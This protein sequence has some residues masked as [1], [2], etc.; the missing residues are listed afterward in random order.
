MSVSIYGIDTLPQNIKFQVIGYYDKD[1]EGYESKIENITF[2]PKIKFASKASLDLFEL[3]YKGATIPDNFKKLIK[4]SLE[5]QNNFGELKPNIQETKE[6]S[7]GLPFLPNMKNVQE[8]NNIRI[9]FKNGKFMIGN[10]EIELFDESIN[11]K[12]NSIDEFNKI[13]FLY[14][15]YKDNKYHVASEINTILKQVNDN[16]YIIWDVINNKQVQIKLDIRKNDIRQ[17]D[18][19]YVYLP[20]YS[21]I[22]VYYVYGYYDDKLIYFK[23]V[24]YKIT[25]IDDTF[26]DIIKK[27]KNHIVESDI[28]NIDIHN[29]E[30]YIT[31]YI[32]NI[33]K[34]NLLITN[35]FSINDIINAFYKVDEFINIIKKIYKSDTYIIDSAYQSIINLY[36]TFSS[37]L[38]DNANKI[39]VR[40]YDKNIIE[41]NIH[42]YVNSLN[43]GN[44]I[45]N[46]NM[47]MNKLNSTIHFLN[48]L[49]KDEGDSIIK[50][51]DNI[52]SKI[53]DI[54]NNIKFS[55]MKIRYTETV[56]KLKHDLTGYITNP[57]VQ[58][59][60]DD[61]NE[62]TFDM[63]NN[64]ILNSIKTKLNNTY[65][66]DSNISEILEK[67]YIQSYDH[68]ILNIL[69]SIINGKFKS[70]I[71]EYENTIKNIKDELLMYLN[72]QVNNPT[73]IHIISKILFDSLTPNDILNFIIYFNELNS[74]V[75]NIM[76]NITFVIE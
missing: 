28:V 30:N 3:L 18:N 41:N 47:P 57:N 50:K 75:E 11:K 4:F 36:Y 46:K 15:M 37:T 32:S 42:K 71:D 31:E 14:F 53:G 66:I 54:I 48:E 1:D 23:N 34:Y 27:N 68:I 25:K 55:K 52:L 6:Y 39:L 13:K 63:N 2:D 60:D 72:I 38:N 40:H 12:I 19:K 29:F 20:I 45:G 56:N 17:L 73:V 49:K 7:D 8:Y 69:Y 9:R 51:I 64:F 76:N 35:I 61:Y 44:L 67:T 70:K 24:D 33:S 58:K 74:Y 5:G 59:I 22:Q 10:I 65:K 43:L 16:M 26:I 62:L 21:Y